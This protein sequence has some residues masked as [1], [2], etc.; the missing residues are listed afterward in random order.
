MVK[1]WTQQKL[2]LHVV[3]TS[4]VNDQLPQHTTI[5]LN[6]LT[7]NRQTMAEP[8]GAGAGLVR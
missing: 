2:V 1:K 7:H 8:Y 5:Q 4:T 3:F 6:T